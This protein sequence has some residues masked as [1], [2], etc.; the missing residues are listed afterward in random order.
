MD[1]RQ[2][3]YFVAVADH[4]SMTK[5]AESLFVSQP[6]VS[7]QIRLL[8][9]D[10]GQSLFIRRPGGV[11]L[12]DAGRT[13]LRYAL[14]LLQNIQDARVALRTT[15]R[16]HGT[17]HVGVLPTLTRSIL[18]NLIRHY[19]EIEPDHQIVVT[20]SSTTKLLKLVLDG[21]VQVAILDLPVSDPLLYVEKLWAE[22]LVLI[23]P[24]PWWFPPGPIS[25][26]AVRRY[27][28]ITMETGYG[29]RDVLFRHAQ[30]EGFNPRIIME[31]TSLGAL[32][33]FVQEE[34][35]L[36]VVPERTVEL[37]VRSRLI[38]ALP[39]ATGGMRDVGMI[40]RSHRPLTIPVQAFVDF[41]RGVG[42]GDAG[43]M[44]GGLN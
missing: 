36:S 15:Q 9:E 40:W 13:L 44:I 16:I 7:Q 21:D 6:T 17:I 31:L 10:I 26:N 33:G 43:I 39:L 42:R 38:Q 23:A 32:I 2:L 1:I 22:S 3:E 18:P 37:E 5:G 35:G 20:E 28:F 19:Q 30:E 12:T 27:P 34:F 8:E 24:R 14:R 11:E 29:L 4:G 41:L 25:L